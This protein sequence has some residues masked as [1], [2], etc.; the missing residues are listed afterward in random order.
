MLDIRIK[1]EAKKFVSRIL[2]KNLKISIAESCTGGLFSSYVTYF[3][4]VSKVFIESIVS[5]SNDSKIK[6]LGVPDEI[7]KKHGAVS[8]P[9]A[10][11]M[12]EKVKGDS[13]IG[14]GITG[15]AGPGGGT[16]DK[17]VGLVY[18]AVSIYDNTYVK[19]L[20]LK[21]NRDRIRKKTCLEVFMFLSKALK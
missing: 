20:N 11:L 7:I 17:P 6:R 14:I 10:R 13:D 5:Y 9:V 4:G 8:E 3:P 1:R 18:F 16:E 2:E 19:R 15:I 12:A 21:G